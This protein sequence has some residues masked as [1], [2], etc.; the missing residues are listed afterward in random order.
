MAKSALEKAID[1]QNK[2]NA[3][4]ERKSRNGRIDESII[5]GQPILFGVRILD[6]DSEAMLNAILSRYDGIKAS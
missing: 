1:R 3:K 6:S 4:A 2:A 5:A